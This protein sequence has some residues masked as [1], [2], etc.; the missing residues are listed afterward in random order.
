[1]TLGYEIRYGEKN[2]DFWIRYNILDYI[3][4][5]LETTGTVFFDEEPIQDLFDPGSGM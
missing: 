3:S 4:E 1:L 5:S 2:P